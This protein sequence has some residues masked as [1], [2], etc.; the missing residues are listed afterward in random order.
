MAT[1]TKATS[2]PKR[3][4]ANNATTAAA[5]AQPAD[6]L[7]DTQGRVYH[8]ALNVDAEGNPQTL[9]KEG[10]APEGFH[11]RK[12]RPLVKSHFASEDLYYDYQ[13]E[14]YAKKSA[15][16]KEKAEEIRKLGTSGDRTKAKKLLTLTKRMEDLKRQLE[17]QGVNVEELMAL[18]T[19]KDSD[20]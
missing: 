7:A 13:S 1:K 16:A 11:H 5:D 19:P 20:E 17:A 8:P 2:T 18:E 15:D 9:L 3:T 14:L 10:T 4:K 12:H 6:P